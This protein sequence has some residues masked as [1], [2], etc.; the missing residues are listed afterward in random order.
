MLRLLWLVLCWVV[1][2][3]VI[4]PQVV[5]AAGIT[6]DVT[7]LG[8]FNIRLDGAAISDQLGY[9]GA[10]LG[11][12]AFTDID[13]DGKQDLVIGAALADNGGKNSSGS[14]YII[15]GDILDN[16]TGTGNTI[17]LANSNNYSV[18]IDGDLVSGFLT[19]SAGVIFGDLNNDGKE[20]MLIS[21]SYADSVRGNVF[22]IYHDL[23]AGYLSSVGNVMDLSVSSNYNLI[24]QG[25]ATGDS[26]G[27]LSLII[28]DLDRDNKN[29]ILLESHHADNN[30]RAESGSVFV[31]FNTLLDDYTGTGNLINVGTTSNFSLRIDGAEAGHTF[32]GGAT[33]IGDYNGD[34][35]LDLFVG[36]DLTDYNTR[37][38]SGSIWIFD[39]SFI[40]GYAGTSANIVDMAVSSPWLVR[41]DGA[42]AGDLMSYGNLLIIDDITHDGK[43]DIVVGSYQS[44]YNSRANS[45]SVWIIENATF[46][47][48]TGTGNLV[49]LATA[50]NYRVRIDGAETSDNFSFTSMGIM[51]MNNNGRPDLVVGSKLANTNGADSG[52]VY[53]FLDGLRDTWST[54]GTTIDTANTNNFNLRYDGGTGH[55]MFFQNGYFADFNQD[56]QLDYILNSRNAGYNSRADSGSYF[57]I[58]NFPHTFTTAAVATTNIQPTL[59]GSIQAPNSTSTVAGVA[60]QIDS[61]SLTG[62]WTSCTADDG[63]FNSTSEN[64][65]CSLLSSLTEGQHTVYF[66]A[67]DSHSTYTA[68]SNFA[69]MSLIIDTNQ[70]TSAAISPSGYSNQSMPTLVTPFFSDVA[71]TLSYYFELDADKYRNYTI[72]QLPT[73]CGVTSECVERDTH[74]AKV[75]Y[76]NEHDSNSSNNLIEVFFKGLLSNP[77]SEGVHHW[78]VTAKDVVDHATT[79]EATLVMDFTAPKVTEVV[80]PQVGAVQ[81]NM[82]YPLNLINQL[83]VLGKISDPKKG[84]VTRYP[85]GAVDE[86]AADAAGVR[87][88]RLVLSYKNDQG[89]YQLVGE[90]NPEVR[91]AAAEDLAK[92]YNF[93]EALPHSLARGIYR[94]QITGTDH[95]SNISQPVDYYF[96]NGY[97]FVQPIK[98]TKAGEFPMGGY[99]PNS[100]EPAKNAAVLGVRDFQDTATPSPT[101]LPTVTPTTAVATQAETRGET[102]SDSALPK[103]N[104]LLGATIGA[105][106]LSGLIFFWWSKAR[107]R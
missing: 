76:R 72:G 85:D 60:Y 63:T 16:Y 66:R 14:I 23:F 54:P 84:S 52:A 17:D 55:R 97:L 59:T 94:L 102:A 99:S 75:T 53:I 70:P 42:T 2:S 36:S 7:N 93:G 77:L 24:I 71:S 86:Y 58:Y 103:T 73:S 100:T 98:M 62:T 13:G 5:S 74:L 15:S 39:N 27:N 20:D 28:A 37:A 67:I 41:I 80:L 61:N 33:A 25:A 32:G 79:R 4:Q 1:A 22:L 95:A 78:K 10:S 49:D 47:E 68:Q 56:G 38:N 106:G 88:V 83:A 30:G 3:L 29:D 31:F 96:A 92:I 105:V 18:R 9:N 64:F 21:E 35:H 107:T 51:D 65:S 12:K 81:P 34:G 40:A 101:P 89:V 19:S 91:Q 57:L 46:G 6:V 8:S 26:F 45:G 104:W 87:E 43:D 69:T 50:T 82:L 44:D 48:L 90:S 11:Q